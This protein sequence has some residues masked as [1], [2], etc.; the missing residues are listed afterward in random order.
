MKQKIKSLLRRKGRSIADGA[1][2]R[3]DAY[4]TKH[5]Q[6][7][8]P[9]L[10]SPRDV[11][12][13][14]RI[15]LGRAPEN[16]A[17]KCKEDP[18]DLCLS[19]AQSDE[20]KNRVKTEIM[21]DTRSNQDYWI[22]KTAY[23]HIITHLSD[24]VIG[25]S[26]RREGAFQEGNISDALRLTRELG[27][28]T[29]G[30][31]FLDIGSNIGTHTLYALKNGFTDAVC[32]EPDST[33]YML[34]RVNQILNGIDG[35]CR[36]FLVAASDYDGVAELEL[37]PINFGDHRIRRP[38][39]GTKSI[40][41]HGEGTWETRSTKVMRLDTLL[42][43]QHIDARQSGIAWID[44]Q[45]HEG[46]VLSGANTLLAAKTPIVAEFWPYG[47]ERSGGYACLR[48]ALG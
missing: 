1:L 4:R 26:L 38:G 15:L 9:P 12:R 20:R 5:K 27:V 42:A 33:N 47:L 3:Y 41:V 30:T 32:I 34:L 7:P 18:L 19:V 31:G 29:N 11:D 2:E 28:A 10:I 22:S 45:G 43:E 24:K 13:I 44:T 46:Q 36:N 17:R 6:L 37:S 48:E 39:N 21:D 8:K 25:T 40:P 14:Y 16:R 35:K 23:G